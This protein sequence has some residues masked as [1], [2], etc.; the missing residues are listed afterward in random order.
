MGT[1]IVGIVIGAVCSPV[2][3]KLLIVGIKALH[4]QVNNL[5]DRV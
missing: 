1:L 4:K 3:Y 5:N 2:L